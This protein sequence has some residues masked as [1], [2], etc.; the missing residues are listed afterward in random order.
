MS[1]DFAAPDVGITHLSQLSQ[2]PR[3]LLAAE[4]ARAFKLIADAYAQRHSLG[5]L[6]A[7]LLEPTARSLGDLWQSDE[8]SEL[9]VT[10]GLCRMQTAVCRL[11]LSGTEPAMQ[12]ANQHSALLA[13]QPGEPP[14]LDATTNAI[15]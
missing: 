3:L 6:C 15:N 14:M 13:T 5:E 2:L 7:M 4:P 10:L 9:D 12:A 11:D 1:D 8:C